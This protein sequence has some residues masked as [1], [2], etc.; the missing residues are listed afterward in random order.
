[1]DFG[2]EAGIFL[3]YTAGLMVIYLFGRLLIVP[4]KLL[5]KLLLSSLAGGLILV[6]I[7]FIGGLVS[8]SLPINIL[9]ALIAGVI[10]IPGILGMLLYFN[11]F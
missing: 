7:N 8:I 3:A 9:T 11:L 2:A 6:V 5:L 1:M 4:A 10:G